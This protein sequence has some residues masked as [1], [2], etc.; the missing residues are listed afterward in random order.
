MPH[1]CQ[2][3]G[4]N[5]PV[6]GGGYCKYHQYKRRMYKGDL[7][8]PPEYQHYY[9]PKEGKKRKV[10][11]VYYVVQIKWF[12][13]E[14]VENGTDFCIFCGEHMEKRDNIH[15]MRGRTGDYY[16]D[17]KW[18]VNA[19]NDCHLYYHRATVEQLSKETWYK[20]FLERLKEKDPQSYQKEINKG[21]KT[22]FDED[23]L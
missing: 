11:R 21:Q 12:W 6:F 2:E 22:M 1:I 7:Y 17:K 14:S 15:H 9:I 23:L 13:D 16:L 10:E 3:P 8:K 20:G 19:H 5:N 4:C 18:W